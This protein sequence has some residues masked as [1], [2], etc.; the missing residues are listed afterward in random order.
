MTE[1]IRK[2]P[3]QKINLGTKG[4]CSICKKMFL[5]KDLISV[6]KSNEEQEGFDK[7]FNTGYKYYCKKCNELM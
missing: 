3:N 2:I 7:I 4:K 5:Y 6:S 1:Y